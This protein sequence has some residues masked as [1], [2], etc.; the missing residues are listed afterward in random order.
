[1]NA[2]YLGDTYLDSRDIQKEIDKLEA[3]D[4]LMEDEKAELEL[5]REFKDKYTGT[6]WEY[7]VTFILE[8]A[9]VDYTIEFVE[10][11][12]YIS[13]DFPCWIEVDWEATARN[14]KSDYSTIEVDGFTY[15]YR[16]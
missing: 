16:E 3:I 15:L 4:D 2:I 6:E 5:W 11:C 12:G 13:P 9:F 14:L 1:M 8:S 10:D 7:G